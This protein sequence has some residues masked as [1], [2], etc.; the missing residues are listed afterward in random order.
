[1]LF[2]LLCSEMKGGA[3]IETP[4]ILYLFLKTKYSNK[5]T[6]YFGGGE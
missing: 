6:Q 5:L 4:P 3:N 1:M 2:L